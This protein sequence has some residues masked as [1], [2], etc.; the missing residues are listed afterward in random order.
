MGRGIHYG[1]AASALAAA[2]A[3]PICA[4]SAYADAP[5][6]E[7]V[8][9]DRHSPTRMLEEARAEDS[10]VTVSYAPLAEQLSTQ[11]RRAVILSEGIA[12]TVACVTLA[13]RRRE[14]GNECHSGADAEAQATDVEQQPA[15]GS[16]NNPGTAID[17]RQDDENPLPER[18]MQARQKAAGTAIARIA[19]A[20]WAM[21]LTLQCLLAILIVSMSATF[22]RALMLGADCP[23]ELQNL[24]TTALLM[25]WGLLFSFAY[26]HR[27]SRMAKEVSSQANAKSD[28]EVMSLLKRH[29][30]ETL[31]LSGGL[32]H[33]SAGWAGSVLSAVILLLSSIP[34]VMVR[35]D[36]MRE[37]HPDWSAW[38][39][40]LSG[41]GLT[42]VTLILAAFGTLIFVVLGVLMLALFRTAGFSV[43]VALGTATFAV[44]VFI[45]VW[46]LRGV[47]ARRKHAPDP[48][49]SENQG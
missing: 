45:A 37:A 19:Y 26:M 5:A 15:S 43:L 25:L 21:C 24:R 38:R 13:R 39:I 27:C 48:G 23:Y 44:S 36:R 29:W 31:L 49:A 46:L 18:P 47:L 7:T 3:L 20:A 6:Q 35:L 12:I 42:S 34:L 4:E 17:G 1:M 40:V 8:S 33:C 11:S 41:I 30:A 16:G 32:V 14:D 9:S 10:M 28:S 2:M 22:A